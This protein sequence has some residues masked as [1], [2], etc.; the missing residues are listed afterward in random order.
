MN[1]YKSSFAFFI[2]WW[3]GVWGQHGDPIHDA[4]LGGGAFSPASGI[5]FD[6]SLVSESGGTLQLPTA[7]QNGR[8]GAGRWAGANLIY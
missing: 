3:L 5:C 2:L 6:H 4:D 8:S 1:A 7:G